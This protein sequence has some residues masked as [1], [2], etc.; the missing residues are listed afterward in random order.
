MRLKAIVDEMK[1]FGAVKTLQDLGLRGFNRLMTARVLKGVTIR[2][3]DPEFLK[4][5]KPYRGGFLSESQLGELVRN[6]PEYEMSG[7][8]LREAFA[9]GDE[10]YG[11]VDG[12]VLAAYGWYSNRPTAI[13]APGMELHFDS[14]YIY[15]YKGFTHEKYRGQRLH[16]IA[17]T[18]AL[19]AYLEKGF[20][21]LVSYVEWNNFGSLK[22]CYRIGYV[23]F[24]NLYLVKPFGRYVTWADRSCTSYGFR[25]EHAPEV[26]PE[27][28]VQAAHFTASDQSR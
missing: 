5:D 28:R 10:C 7:Q 2:T 22:S 21:G 9:K 26:R 14:R 15:M 12:G 20:H 18:R 6:R 24:G 8:F 25:L 1:R 11:F 4:C 16:A 19:E 13:D 3:V 27:P 23:D 17:M